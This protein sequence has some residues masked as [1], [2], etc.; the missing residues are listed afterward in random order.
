MAK[1]NKAWMDDHDDAHFSDNPAVRKR[2]GKRRHLIGAGTKANGRPNVIYRKG[3]SRKSTRKR[4]AA[5]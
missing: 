5:K 4:V 2:Q 1:K 3:A